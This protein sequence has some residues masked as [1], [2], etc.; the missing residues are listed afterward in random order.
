MLALNKEG[1]RSLGKATLIAGILVGFVFGFRIQMGYM[2][3]GQEFG[4]IGDYNRVV[5]LVEESE[6]LEL[7]R[8][9]MRRVAQFA[10]F[11]T[12]TNFSVAVENADGKQAVL[13]F[14][15][16][17]PELENSSREELREYLLDRAHAEFLRSE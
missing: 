5:N 2:D 6:E 15:S 1:L 17:S 13:T 14:Q 8:S 9:R 12:V 7:V 3:V 10:F 4:V 16:G 11:S